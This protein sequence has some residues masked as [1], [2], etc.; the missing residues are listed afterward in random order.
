MLISETA[1]G[2][3]QQKIARRM[4]GV[5]FQEWLRPARLSSPPGRRQRKPE[6]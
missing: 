6:K 4:D 1:S 2:G 5:R 3:F